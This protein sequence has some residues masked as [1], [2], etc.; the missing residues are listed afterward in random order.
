MSQ[1][2]SA[3]G[4]Q[5]AGVEAVFERNLGQFDNLISHSDAAQQ[6]AQAKDE[7]IQETKN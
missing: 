4:D 7:A 2:K 6:L 5:L 1:K 3:N